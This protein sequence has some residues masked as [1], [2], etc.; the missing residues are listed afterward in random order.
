MTS[1]LF[2]I[3]YI[4]KQYIRFLGI[5][6]IIKVSVKVIRLGLQLQLITPTLTLIILDITKPHPIIVTP[7]YSIGNKNI[8]S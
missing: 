7:L 8:L 1:I 5:S 4:R 6:R 2:F 3:Q